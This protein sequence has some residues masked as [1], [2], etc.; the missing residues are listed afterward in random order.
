MKAI[1]FESFGTANVLIPVELPRPEPRADEVL[2]QVVAAGVSFVDIRQRQ[3][4][5]NRAETRV[6]GVALP[7]VPGLQAVGR[8]VQL[9]PQGDPALLGRKVVTFVD[10]GA[11]A[12]LLIA[13]SSLCVVAPEE[14][15]DA[16]LSV[17]PMQGLTA[18]LAL[19]AS[20]TLRKG[21]SVLIH[22][23]GSGVGSLAVQIARILGA[24]KIVATAATP[25]K[26][27]FARTMGA[28]VV[29]DYT[30]ADWTNQ[31]L[32][33]TGGAGVDVL[34][35]S[36]GGAVFEQNFECLAKFG[37]YII[38]GSTQGL[39][40]PVEA[41]RLMTRC[42]SLTGL[43]MP[44]YTARPD[45]LRQGLSFLVEHVAN[46]ALRAPVAAQLPLHEAAKAHQMLEDRKVVG[47]V[48]LRP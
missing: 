2:I 48:V 27:Q 17:L 41:R 16:T 34:L 3:G 1:Q 12:E 11:Y 35:E 20:T 23:A 39:G 7:N 18:F 22:A 44:V 47:S 29:V 8:V 13:P 14:A 21:E 40:K 42:Q 31:V 4:M 10:K 38:Y 26:R 33:A 43:Y 19:S 45:L 36:I 9:G 46:G 5:Y 24:G 28:D 30:V 37:R 32:E 6:G 15:D 25:E